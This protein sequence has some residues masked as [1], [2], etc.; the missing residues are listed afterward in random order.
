[1]VVNFI[2]NKFAGLRENKAYFTSDII[3]ANDITNIELFYTGINGGVGIR[4]AKGNVSI[5]NIPENE[6]IVNIF[7]SIQGGSTYIFIH[8][9]SDTEGKLY[10][11]DKTNS[12]F[13]PKITGLTKSTISSGVDFQQGYSDLFLFCNG[14][15]FIKK[16]EI[17]AETE[18]SDL[19]V[20]DDEKRDIK[21]NGLAVFNGRV[22]AFLDNRIHWSKQ[23]DVSVWNG[24]NL[25]ISTSAGYMEFP[26]TITALTNYLNSLVVFFKDSSCIFSGEYPSFTVTEESPGGCSGNKALVFHG[27]D[28]FFFDYNKR[29]IYSFQQVVLGNKVLGK[30]IGEE[31]ASY[32]Q[33]IDASRLSE[34][35]AKSIIQDDRNEIW[36]LL[37]STKTTTAY[38][39][40]EDKEIAETIDISLILIYDVLRGEWVK[41][42][43]PKI[44][45]FLQID[46]IIYSGNKKLYIEY[47]G[48]SFDG[49]FIPCEYLC[50]NFNFGSNTSLKILYLSPR[51]TVSNPYENTFW[52]DYIK[53]FGKRK[54]TKFIKAKYKDI[55]RWD[56]AIWDKSKWVNEQ[57][58]SLVKLPNISAFKNLDIRFFTKTRK[59]NFAIQQLEM[60]QIDTIQT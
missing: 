34:I 37:P 24:G 10:L 17:G 59:E 47:V 46:N 48:Q 40:Q 18:V 11:Y 45:D 35:T 22:F 44:Y 36:F 12:V 2:C 57:S 23:Q 26:K 55:A 1:M 19:N 5:A 43:E 7:K 60:N 9:I 20:Q 27:T 51:I 15:D 6:R 3:T 25:E 21:P 28:L 33:E 49:Y 13:I 16:I 50:S 30:N 41:R 56:K 39:I 53:N 29:S 58:D 31:V 54:K 32:F 38:K 14:K 52:I 4:T 8:T 42:I